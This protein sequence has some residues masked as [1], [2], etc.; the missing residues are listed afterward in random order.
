MSERWK[1]VPGWEDF[2]YVHDMVL[3]AFVGPKPAGLEVCHWNGIRG[4]NRL[5]NLRYDT[6]KANAQDRERHKRA[7]A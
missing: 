1:D 2:Y 5:D 7:A 3:A 6:R 4:D